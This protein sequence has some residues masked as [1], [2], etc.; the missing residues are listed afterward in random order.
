MREEES[1]MK[2]SKDEL[3]EDKFVE[4]DAAA[5]VCDGDG[6]H[7]NE[8][9]NHVALGPAFQNEPIRIGGLVYGCDALVKH[10]RVARRR[11]QMLGH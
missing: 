6:G 10:V 3:E 7:D 8:T 11:A 5:H 4:Q 9:S 1:A 2:G